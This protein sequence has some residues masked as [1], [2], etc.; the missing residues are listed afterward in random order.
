MVISSGLNAEQ[1]RIISEYLVDRGVL[2]EDAP[3]GYRSI[4]GIAKTLG[5]ADKIVRRAVHELEET[6]G[7]TTTYHFGTVCATGYSPE[8]QEQIVEYLRSNGSLEEL[9]SK[10]IASTNRLMR[11][12]HVGNMAIR[13]A[14]SLINSELGEV[15]RYRFG[16]AVATGYTPAQQEMIR[17]AIAKNPQP[18]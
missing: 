4:K 10:D 16:G 2:S 1:Q 18:R 7:D 13:R 6:L 8:Q 12:L 17:Q 3:E 11:E 15:K 14:I 9:A 5:V